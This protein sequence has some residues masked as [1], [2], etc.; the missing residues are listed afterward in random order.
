MKKRPSHLAY[1]E[2]S[3][4]G[5]TLTIPLFT[6]LSPIRSTI[7]SVTYVPGTFV[8]L[9][10]GPHTFAK[11]GRKGD[12]F[13]GLCVFAG[14]IP[15]FGCGCAALG[16]SWLGLLILWSFCNSALHHYPH[17]LWLDNQYFTVNNFVYMR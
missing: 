15:N 2:R 6:P 4:S 1:N 14:D 13:S 17:L 7:K 5:W 8:T 11:G 16:S 3:R 12:F 10:S 9:V